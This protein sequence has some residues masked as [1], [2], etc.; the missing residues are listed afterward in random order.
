MPS[1]GLSLLYTFWYYFIFLL[2]SNYYSCILSWRQVTSHDTF[3]C[4]KQHTVLE[5][6]DIIR[7]NG[8]R[9]L[10]ILGGISFWGGGVSPY[11]APFPLQTGACS[12]CSIWSSI[13]KEDPLPGKAWWCVSRCKAATEGCRWVVPSA[14][15]SGRNLVHSQ[16]VLCQPLSAKCVDLT[17]VPS[18]ISREHQVE[19]TCCEA[20]SWKLNWSQALSQQLQ[21]WVGH[22]LLPAHGS[23]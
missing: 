22:A 1:G 6:H 9:R 19:E 14:R 3:L 8:F 13:P 20:L 7:Q 2:A 11:C 4:V 17:V 23:V 15:P 10:I 5:H 16:C 12:I 21:R 18:L